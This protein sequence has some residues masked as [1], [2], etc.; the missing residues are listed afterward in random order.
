MPE[1]CQNKSGSVTIMWITLRERRENESS[2]VDTV[3]LMMM[4]KCVAVNVFMLSV[5]SPVNTSTVA[6]IMIRVSPDT[7]SQ[8]SFM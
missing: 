5:L 2:K 8:V 7:A 4:K 1:K 6:V 3:S